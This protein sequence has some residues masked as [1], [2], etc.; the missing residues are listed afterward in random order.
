MCML[1][2]TLTSRIFSLTFSTTLID[3]LFFPSMVTMFNSFSGFTHLSPNFIANSLVHTE[4]W[5]PVSHCT[6]KECCP[7][8][9]Y[10]RY[11]GFSSN[12]AF[13]TSLWF[14][15][16]TAV[17]YCC[18]LSLYLGICTKSSKKVFD[19]VHL[20]S[21][22][23]SYWY[24]FESLL[25]FTWLSSSSGFFKIDLGVVWLLFMFTSPS[26]SSLRVFTFD[27]SARQSFLKCPLYPQP[28][29]LRFPLSFW[30]LLGGW[31]SNCFLFHGGLKPLPFGHSFSNDFYWGFMTWFCDACCL[32]C[33][34]VSYGFGCHSNC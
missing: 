26:S 15:H 17:K 10:D 23:M 5:A 34:C 29:H 11:T 27:P 19:G 9:T 1:I 13:L 8:F 16:S 20:K 2:S 28:W 22:T 25:R 33:G 6:C 14:F 30:L 4:I 18:K 31:L 24:G 3:G 7:N 12:A 21:L 32:C